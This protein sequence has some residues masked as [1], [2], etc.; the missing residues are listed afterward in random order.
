MLAADVWGPL[1][2]AF[3][4]LGIL[5]AVLVTWWFARGPRLFVQV[6]GTT[7]VSSP[8]REQI[9]VLYGREVVP[10]V[11]Q[12]LI[13]LWRG[14][15]G[16]I[17]GTDIVESDPLRV[18]VSP[19][20]RLLD[21]AVLAQS[22]PT[23]AVSVAM[24]ADSRVAIDFDYLDVRQG[25][26]IEVLHTAE[27]PELITIAGT[28]IGIPKGVLRVTEGVEVALPI[29]VVGSVSITVPTRSI[30]RSLRVASGMTRRWSFLMTLAR[31]ISAIADVVVGSIRRL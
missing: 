5:I 19:G 6:S 17:R 1:G 16:A 29:G 9:T 13:W 8:A 15:R 20:A 26:V 23:N 7:L 11:T 4:V 21:A 2:V 31:S 22:K 30:P 28:I 10:R 14:G 3:A 27:S 18:H 12:T 25:A 24:D